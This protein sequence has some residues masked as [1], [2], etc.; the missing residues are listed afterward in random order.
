MRGDRKILPLARSGIASPAA[1]SP[2]RHGGCKKEA[3]AAPLAL[4][5]ENRKSSALPPCFS[6]EI[7]A[8][9]GTLF[10]ARVGWAEGPS[11]TPASGRGI[12]SS[13]P[14]SFDF[15]HVAHFVQDDKKRRMRSASACSVA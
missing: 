2:A 5:Y 1:P 6:G 15:V 10:S 13:C 7:K 9:D 8:N 4:C 11:K 14:R 3:T 12:L